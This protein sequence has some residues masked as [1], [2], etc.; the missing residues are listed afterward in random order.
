MSL[1]KS[2]RTIHVSI[3]KNTG[4]IRL[5]RP[6]KRNALNAVMVDELNQ[7]FDQLKE[8]ETVKAITLYGDKNA[9]CSGA[10]LVHLQQ[11]RNND[12]QDNYEDSLSL[13]MLYVKMYTLPKP[14]IAV[15][16]GAA[17]AGGCGLASV[18]D[19]VFSTPEANF[20]Y[21][22]VRIGFIAAM[23]SVFLVRQVGERRARELLLSGKIV[24]AREALDMGLVNQVIESKYIDTEVEKTIDRLKNNSLAAMG[25]TKML[26]AK[27]IE[28]EIEQLAKINADFRQN[29]D[30]KEGVLAFIEKRKPN[31]ATQ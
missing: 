3:E 7:A 26:L 23:V 4:C 16:E 20:G 11:I 22:E 13:G 19:F 10:D 31:W 18:C 27:G 9:F 24:G 15:V 14:V 29:D 8:D 21:P 30:F 5:N 1:N 12:W 28:K 17:L 25:R 2:F 6:E